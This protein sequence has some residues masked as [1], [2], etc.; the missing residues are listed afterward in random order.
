MVK[1]KVGEYLASV[2][3]AE[4]TLAYPKLTA[5][6]EEGDTQSNLKEVGLTTATAANETNH[7]PVSRDSLEEAEL[8]PFWSLLREAGYEVW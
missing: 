6:V 5:T 2:V 3:E 4:S 7:A 8:G 1:R